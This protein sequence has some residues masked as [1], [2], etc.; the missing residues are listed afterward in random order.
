MK[1]KIDC[2]V[3][4]LKVAYVREESAAVYVNQI[5]QE[6]GHYIARS[7]M[8]D[9]SV[10]RTH[11]VC[12]GSVVQRFLPCLAIHPYFAP[13]LTHRPVAWLAP[14]SLERHKV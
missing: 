14:P 3:E 12:L 6:D 10:E 4:D 1:E 13:P 7:G 2:A 8:S 9:Y 5:N 11:R